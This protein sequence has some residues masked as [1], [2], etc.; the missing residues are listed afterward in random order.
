VVF[1]GVQGYISPNWYPSKQETHRHVPTWNYE[2]VHA[3]GFIR[4][5]DDEKFLRGVVGRLT[6]THE[7]DQ[8]SPWRMSDAPADY[9]A[10]QLTHIVGIEVELTR[11]E[12][13]RK[14]SQNRDARDFE[15]T[16]QALESRGQ[17]DLADAMRR[18]R[19]QG[20]A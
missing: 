15:S 17:T 4:I 6:R 8:A 12:G 20:P 14:L 16:V 7:A 13:K 18:A 2:V 1:R 19:E 3:H 10:E 5:R 11:I 9:L